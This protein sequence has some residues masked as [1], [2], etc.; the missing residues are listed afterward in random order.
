MNYICWDAV[1]EIV[2]SVSPNMV[3]IWSVV[4]GECIQELGS[5]GNQFYSCVFHP[6]YS[7]LLVI[8]GF[9]V[10]FLFTICCN[11]RMD[12][13]RSI[14]NGAICLSWIVM[15]YLT[16]FLWGWLANPGKFSTSQLMKRKK[17]IYFEKTFFCSFLVFSFNYKTTNLF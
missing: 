9:S 14:V 10:S 2:A 15:D 13:A 12:W 1:G 17:P 6:S 5:T 8:G 16:S 11:E 7:T 4:S 3:K